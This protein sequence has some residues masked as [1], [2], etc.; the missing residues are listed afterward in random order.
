M[1][2]PLKLPCSLIQ[3]LADA[4]RTAAVLD[5]DGDRLAELTNG[6]V[7][8]GMADEIRALVAEVRQIEATRD[9][10]RGGSVA[11]LKAEALR[12]VS[13]IS[14]AARWAGRE[15]PELRERFERVRKA[16]P[17]RGV[18]AQALALALVTWQAFTE[19][20]ASNLS[21]FRTEDGAH[22][23]AAAA[24]LSAART[25]AVAKLTNARL[26]LVRRDALIGA[27]SGKLA[28]YRG[29]QSLASIADAPS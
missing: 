20:E 9:R 18:G 24:G 25:H 22:L 3:F 14:A 8:R 23:L 12:L 2:K 1:A 4:D 29:A 21:G 10:G 28:L 7:H 5:R 15:D 27:L 6:R 13:R 17:V 19:R 16:A 26:E 11:P